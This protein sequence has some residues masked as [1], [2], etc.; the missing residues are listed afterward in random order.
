MEGQR[1]ARLHVPGEDAVSAGVD[2]GHGLVALALLVGCSA[3]GE[4]LRL[5]PTVPAVRAGNEGERAALARDR[6]ER[7]PEGHHRPAAHGPVGLVVVPARRLRRARLLHEELVVEEVE[8]FGAQEPRRQLP[9][10]P[11]AAEGA[12]A[13]ILLPDALVTVEAAH[14]RPVAGEIRPRLRNIAFDRVLQHAEPRGRHDTLHQHRAIAVEIRPFARCRPHG[15]LLSGPT[16]GPSPTAARQRPSSSPPLGA[17]QAVTL[18]PHAPV[19]ALARTR[20]A[21]N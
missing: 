8:A 13:L 9:E 21:T 1:I 10:R 14:L 11:L 18:D 2:I 20:R 16:P 17:T 7:Q 5:E 4:G 19:L 12:E 3:F 15:I 6:V